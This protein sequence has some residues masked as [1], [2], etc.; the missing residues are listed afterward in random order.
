M[1][2]SYASSYSSVTSYIPSGL[3]TVTITGA[4]DSYDDAAVSIGYGA[5]EE[6]DMI[7]SLTIGD[8]VYSIGAY[9]FRDCTSLTEMVVP[10]SVT[11]IGQGA[12]AGCY[13]IEEITLPFVGSSRNGNTSSSNHLFGY[14]FG[15]GDQGSYS[16]YYTGV[17]QSPRGSRL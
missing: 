9:A 13:N 8:G 15:Y 6:C 4:Y 17:T 12:F 5:F 16:S 3:T 11:S 7:D 10:E 14:I 1:T 2:Q